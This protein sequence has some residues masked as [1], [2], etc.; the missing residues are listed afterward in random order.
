MEPRKMAGWCLILF[1]LINVL[2]AIYMQGTQGRGIT[3]LYAFITSL[4]FT[5][6]AAFLWLNKKGRSSRS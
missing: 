2:H 1:G 5:L 3:V 6:G 4:L